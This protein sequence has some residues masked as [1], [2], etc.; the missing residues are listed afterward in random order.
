MQK[1]QRGGG[2]PAAEAAAPSTAEILDI[3]S[4]SFNPND[5]LHN[6]EEHINVASS[7]SD[8]VH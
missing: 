5:Y 2:T 4:I 3:D 8:I 1:Q 6:Q 7:I